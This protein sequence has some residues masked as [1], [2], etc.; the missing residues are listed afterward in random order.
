MKIC[1][2][3][4]N[5]SKISAVREAVEDYPA[6]KEALVVGVEVESGVS[7]QPKSLK[8]SI[9]GAMNRA[10]RAYRSGCVL[11]FGLESGI[12]R[13]P[14]TKTGYMDLCACAIYDGKEFHLGL[15]SAF[16]YPQ[17]I[18]RL[19]VEKGLDATQA[20]LEMGLTD[21][22]KLGSARGIIG[23]LTK[24]RMVRKEYTKQAITTALIHVEYPHLYKVEK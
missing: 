5:R 12:T 15:S 14:Y 1:V 17:K 2:G 19:I 23:I 21:N 18:T 20:A 16:E 3:S 24:D 9:E 7:P 22:P 6:L 8:E 10:K 13:V 11:S 4:K